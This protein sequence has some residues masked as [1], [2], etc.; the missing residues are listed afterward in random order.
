VSLLV[1]FKKD[2]W[3]QAYDRNKIINNNPYLAFEDSFKCKCGEGIV[4]TPFLNIKSLQKNKIIENQY[5]IL[6]TNSDESITLVVNSK[7]CPGLILRENQILRIKGYLS[8]TNGEA[9]INTQAGYVE[10][11]GRKYC[12]I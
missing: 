8:F 2:Q 1:F 10:F 3:T 4:V 12:E 5:W 7:K 6:S 9:Q 11:E